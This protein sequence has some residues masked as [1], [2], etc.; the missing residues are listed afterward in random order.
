[1]KSIV[2][3]PPHFWFWSLPFHAS[4]LFRQLFEKQR[5]STGRA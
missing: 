1:M 2:V 5:I 3:K 4:L